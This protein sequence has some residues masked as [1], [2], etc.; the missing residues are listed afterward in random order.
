MSNT[1]KK[2]NL[3]LDSQLLTKLKII[4]FINNQKLSQTI[5]QFLETQLQS[6]QKQN[7][8]I[9]LNQFTQSP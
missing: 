7:P 3:N 6:F 1:N 2:I 5:Q 9:N 8:K 4:S